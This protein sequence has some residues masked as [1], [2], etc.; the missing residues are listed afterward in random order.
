MRALAP[1]ESFVKTRCLFYEMAPCD[2]DLGESK[3]REIR[4]AEEPPPGRELP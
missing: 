3:A 1:E 2:L 4:A